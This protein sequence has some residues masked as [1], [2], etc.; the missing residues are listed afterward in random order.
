MDTTATPHETTDIF[1][2][3]SHPVL[4]FIRGVPGSG[5]SYL[6]TTL[7]AAIGKDK[8]IVLDPDATNYKS[9]A[10]TTLSKSLTAEGIDAKFHPYRFL[11]RRAYEGITSNK[12]IVW[13]QPFTDLDG[14]N[15]TVINLQAYATER[16][17][18]LP[19]L[20]VEV[21][22]SPDVAK[23]RIANRR[24]QGGHGPTQEVFERFVSDYVS[25]SDQGYTT[26]AINGEED[27]SLS[28]TTVIQALQGLIK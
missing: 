23:Q 10:Y 27:I 2:H 18:E 6:A 24:S 1:Q 8:V 25:F 7:Q 19:L 11:R 26:V 20:V 15:K 14:F 3:T 16:N 22:V 4:V 13:N 21:V 17:I 12:I 5:K 9:K 28:V